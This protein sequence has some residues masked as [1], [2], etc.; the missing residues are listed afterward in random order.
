MNI[1]TLGDAT[2]DPVSCFSD[3]S[4]VPASTDNQLGPSN[5][6]ERCKTCEEGN[7]LARR[8]ELWGTGFKSGSNPGAGKKKISHEISI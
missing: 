1:K 7:A 4:E 3:S 6:S 5:Q 8:H 2:G